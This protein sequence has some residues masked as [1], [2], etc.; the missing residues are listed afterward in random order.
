MIISCLVIF[1]NIF[2]KNYALLLD[3]NTSLIL[4]CTVDFIKSLAGVK[5]LRGSKA[6]GSST[7]TFLIPA[8]IASLKSVSTL[9]LETPEIEAV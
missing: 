8:V 4:C 1:F 3:P 9:I 2:Q 7:N 5:Y 6:D